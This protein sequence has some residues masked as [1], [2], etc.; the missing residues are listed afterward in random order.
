MTTTRRQFT[1]EFK[2]AAVRLARE[3]GTPQAQVARELGMRPTCCGRGSGKLRDGLALQQP[4]CFL[5]TVTNRARR[6]KYNGYDA[7]MS[8]CARSATS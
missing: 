5:A 8:A 4:M 6:K 1:R 3:S 7:K 2:L